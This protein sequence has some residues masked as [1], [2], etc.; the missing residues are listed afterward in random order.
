MIKKILIIFLFSIVT[1][2]CQYFEKPVPS[3]QELLQKE[4][5]KINWS[6]VDEMPSIDSCGPIQ[7]KNQRQECFF[8]FLTHII[9]Q[10]LD[11][12]TLSVLYPNVDTIL[13]KVTVF[14]DSTLK[15]EPQFPND[16]TRYDKAIIDSVLLSRLKDF[17]KIHPAV[18]R[19]I[20]V[21]TQF[22]LPVILNVE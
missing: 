9:Q 15:F 6:Q 20:P 3:E 14:P 1:S 13:V 7:D 21:K 4:L 19:G 12:D 8:S 22:I 16:S 10:K 17:P 5:Q 2:S 18:K 11:T